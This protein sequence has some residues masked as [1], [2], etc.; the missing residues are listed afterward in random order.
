MPLPIARTLTIAALLALALAA[1]PAGAQAYRATTPQRGAVTRDGWTN[2]YLLDAGWLYR[3][4]GSNSGVA[5]RFWR[6]TP[7]AAGWS[8]VGVPNSFN[9]AKVSTPSFYGTIGWYRKDFYVPRGPAGERWLVRFESVN[10]RAQVWLNG[11]RIGTH[12]GAFLP[13]ELDLS[14]LR[15]HAVNRLVVRVENRLGPGDLPPGPYAS[16]GTPA[17]G[18]WWNYGG[19][20]G[21]VYVRPVQEANLR[22]VIVRP[23]LACPTCAAS[24][25]EQALVGNV[26]GA[27]VRVRLRG[28][29]GGRPVSFGAATIPPGAT[30]TAHA[31]IHIRH[32]RLWAP[33]SPTLYRASVTLTGSSGQQLATFVTYSGIRMIRVLAGGLLQLNG[34]P[35]HLRGVGLQEANVHTGGALSSAQIEQLVGWDR[36]LGAD[37]IRLQYPAN[38]LLEEL[39]DRDGILIW[40][41]IPV[42]QVKPKY[43]ASASTVS[44]AHTMLTENILDNENHPSI[45]LWSVGNELATPA[46]ASETDYI[47]GAARLAHHLD[48]T[49]PV[50]MAVMGWPG[51]ACQ[52]AY[53]P[54]DVIG[55]NEYFGWYDE[56]DGSTVD[57]SGLGPYLDFFRSCYPHQA[58]FVSEFGFEADRPGPVEEQGT[59]AF[60]SDAISYHLGVIA[61]RPWL[62]GA[63]YW[64]LQDFVCRPLWAGGDPVPDPPF[65]HKGLVDLEGNLKPTFATVEHA[66]HT[67]VQVGGP[68]VP[69]QPILK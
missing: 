11:H 21:D 33:G 52:P 68:P 3:P 35:L 49:R 32:P 60:Q 4:D 17:V 29:F 58:M 44:L 45:L 26:T 48:P 42:Y 18:G 28:S 54:L 50:G 19:I 38:P 55:L 67:T 13:F 24:I 27:P 1:A 57:R 63:I 62:A 23:Q 39:A 25:D 66:F 20:L 12:V 36:Q 47:A 61:Q 53:A 22:Q 64:A 46:D 59:Y 56:N 7:S 6:D 14:G 16:N 37:L 31:A 15:P 51:V 69:A 34:R 43:L 8:P 41:E 65:F 2:R 10:Y 9:T 30:W 40:S 5:R